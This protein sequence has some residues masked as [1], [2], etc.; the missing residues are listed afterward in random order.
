TC[1]RRWR[2]RLSTPCDVMPDLRPGKMVRDCG[3]PLTLLAIRVKP[4]AKAE[5][6]CAACCWLFLRSRLPAMKPGANARA[7]PSE[8]RPKPRPK[9]S[10]LPGLLALSPGPARG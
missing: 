4:A 2:S 6:S 8:L 5:H 7:C 10:D 9:R 3:A 1:T